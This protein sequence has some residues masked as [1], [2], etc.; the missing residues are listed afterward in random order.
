MKDVTI[1]DEYSKFEYKKKI[2]IIRGLYEHGHSDTGG[3][4][5]TYIVKNNT[6]NELTFISGFVN[7]PGKSKYY[8]LKQLESIINL[9]IKE[10]LKWNIKWLY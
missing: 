8:L 10:T 1:V 4:F 6:N 3:P 2:M 7:N 5:F 9:N